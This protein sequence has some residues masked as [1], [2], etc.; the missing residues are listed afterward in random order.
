MSNFFERLY[1]LMTALVHA[2][3]IMGDESFFGEQ[4]PAM[5]SRWLKAGIEGLLQFC[6]EINS[7]RVQAVVPDEVAPSVLRA[8]GAAAH[9]V[10]SQL[11]SD[12][13]TMSRTLQVWRPSRQPR[14]ASAS[15]PSAPIR[16]NNNSILHD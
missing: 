2:T 14:T 1:P 8:P 11:H 12:I 9:F 3:V 13:A 16:G 7:E 10:D 4:S 15:A 5:A 6:A